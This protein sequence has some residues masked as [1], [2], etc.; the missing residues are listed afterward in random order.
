MTPDSSCRGRLCCSSRRQSRVKG[1]CRRK[2]AVAAGKRHS[3]RD[4]ASPALVCSFLSP[5]TVCVCGFLHGT[6]ES[7]RQP[8]RP[9]MHRLLSSV[10]A[11]TLLLLSSTSGQRWS[12]LHGVSVSVSYVCLTGAADPAACERI[13]LFATNAVSKKKQQ[14]TPSPLVLNFH[15][16]IGSESC[17]FYSR[18]A[19]E[20]V[21]PPSRAS[22]YRRTRV[23]ASTSL[24]F[25]VTS[26]RS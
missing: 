9:T 19:R 13:S 6:R 14:L 8:L 1:E 21:Q 4:S 26:L 12:S 3:R 7:R 16:I 2:E 23:C 5:A 17:S 25:P 20:R 18:V 11:V 10:A 15:R 24:P 22:V